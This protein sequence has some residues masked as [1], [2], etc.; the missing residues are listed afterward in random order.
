MDSL[1]QIVLGASVSEAV[2]G[3]KVGNKAILWGA[4]AGTIPDLDALAMHTTDIVSATEIHRGLS[5]SIFFSL[6]LAPIMG[7]GLTKIY[8]KETA[9][10]KDWTLAMF[11]SLFTHP[12][13]DSFTTWGTQLFWPFD[14]RLAFKNIFVIDPIYTL[15]FLILVI[16][17]IFQSKESTNRIKWNRLGLIISSSYMLLSLIF[18]G[19]TFQQFISSLDRQNIAYEEIETRPSPM[20]II[21]WSAN[22]KTKDGF[23]TGN[24]SLFDS[25]KEIKF[26][27]VIPKQDQLITSIQNEEKIQALQRISNGWYTIEEQD[28]QLYF[29]DLRFGRLGIDDPSTPFVFSYKIQQNEQGEIHVTEREKSFKRSKDLPL[30]IWNRIKGN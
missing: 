20:N 14:I 11:L 13:L 7:W 10:L 6:L 29:N 1:T 17:T 8:K 5:H 23:I 26:S 4:I 19:Y 15:P 16:L 18:K 9:T 2:I 24:Y 27:A 12:I 25:K 28:N 3:R 22:V 30:Q 21:L